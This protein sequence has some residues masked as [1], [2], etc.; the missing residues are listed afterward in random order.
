MHI[1]RRAMR[2]GDRG[3]RAWATARTDED[4]PEIATARLEGYVGAGAQHTGIDLSADED[5]GGLQLFV[6]V[7]HLADVW[8]SI[9]TPR[10]RRWL[11]KRF[12]K[13][14]DLHIA[15]LR[16]HDQAFWW[17]IWHS[18]WGW[19]KG[20]PQWRSGNFHWWRF[21]TGKP[22]HSKETI[23]GPVDVLVPMPEGSYLARVTI[24]RSTWKRPRWPWPTHEHRY[25]LTVISRP[26]PDGPYVPEPDEEGNTRS[27]YIPVPGKGEN[28]WDCGGDGTFGMSGPGRTVEKAIGDVVASSL[29]ERKRHAG[30]HTYAEPTEATE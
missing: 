27:G 25:D 1:H 16:Y 5:T 8:L 21:M 7:A 14:W 26:G 3:L 2:E 6:G 12:P 18:K 4:G 24:E 22:V 28:A 13:I 9:G 11:Y 20:T 15:E 10:L 17:S 29:R 30:S 23:E 19:T